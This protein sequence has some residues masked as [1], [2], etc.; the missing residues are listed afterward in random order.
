[1]NLISCLMILSSMLF[2]GS[3]DLLAQEQP[4]GRIEGKVIDRT[5]AEPL[6]G[7]NVLLKGTVMGTSTNASGEFRLRNLPV[8]AF[9]IVVSMVG[10]ERSEMGVAVEANALA[11]VNVQLRPAVIQTQPVIVTA[12]KREQSLR[13]VPLS[14]SVVDAQMI[15]LRN[16]ITIDEALRY[17]PGVNVI[18]NQVN[19]RGM[20]GFSTGIGSRVL[21]LMDGIPLLTGDTKE[22]VWEVIPADQVDRIEIVKGAGSALW[23]S[24]AL[25]G[26]VNVLTKTPTERPK[27]NLR[28]YGGVYSQPFY[29]EW[30]WTPKRRYLN[31]LSL[32]YSRSIGDWGLMFYGRRARD[33][34]YRQNDFYTRYNGYAKVKHRFSPYQN[35]TMVANFLWQRKGN[36]IWWKSLRDAL[37]APADQNSISNFT[38]RWSV[39]LLYNRVAS[40]DFI[41]EAKLMYYDNRF[42]TRNFAGIGSFAHAHTVSAE[43][44]GIYQFRPTRILTF[45]ATGLFDDINTI[46]YGKHIDYGGALYVQYELSF[47]DEVS[48]TAGVR[49]DEQ[50]VDTLAT[51]S[52]LSPKIGLNYAPW[53]GTNFR[54]SVGRGFRAASL[55]EV[56]IS[57]IFA[58]GIGVSPNPDLRA[59]KS[60]SFEIGVTQSIGDNIY[61]DAA[62]FQTEFRDLI[63]GKVNPTGGDSLDIRFEN[64]TR[65][66]IQGGEISIA[67]N[68]IK[69]LLHVEAG[70]TYLWPRDLTEDDFLRFRSRHLLYG[71]LQLHKG[72]LT[73]RIDGRYISRMERID[74][75]LV[76]LAPIPDGHRRVSVKVVDVRALLDL[77]EF[78]LPLRIGFN[79]NNAAQ[80]NYVELMGNIAATRNYVL[81]IDWAP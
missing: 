4:G 19:I 10:Y 13:D 49:F 33:D 47:A 65:A 23:G 32:S 41:W 78:G 45:G 6:E 64:I 40:S 39:S 62:L 52:Q 73:F 50:K 5:T 77:K 68:W 71:S 80:Y 35:L 9:T 29:D 16:S 28:A 38:R 11:M 59:E 12:G 17:V 8:G 60:W 25:G 34:G 61:V 42:Q 7:A 72:F 2:V 75:R 26:V 46:R 20:S 3:A 67:S 53:A 66:R 36:F 70:Y 37:E 54:A 44:Q 74:E 79:V 24:S 43:V 57:A 55:A 30:K 1:M 21:L 76:E 63:E 58:G 18:Q 27:V 15:S 14:V 22:I 81:S 51:N 69:R 56:Y 48:A 31:G